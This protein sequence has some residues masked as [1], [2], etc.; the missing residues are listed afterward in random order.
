MEKQK[1]AKK[2]LNSTITV[3]PPAYLIMAF[4][5]ILLKP[6]KKKE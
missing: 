4:N 5:A 2:E 1:D 6:W 3:R